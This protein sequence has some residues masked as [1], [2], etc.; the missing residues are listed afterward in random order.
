MPHPPVG[1]PLAE[2]HLRDERR[3]H[4][5]RPPEAGGRRRE[6]GGFLLERLEPLVEVAQRLVGE[7]RADL[8][9]VHEPPVV[10]HPRQQ[11]PETDARALGIGEAADHDFLL[12]HALDLE[13]VRRSGAAIDRVAPLGDGAFEAH[14]AG[15]RDELGTGADDV[16]A[17]L[18]RLGIRAGRL[19]QLREQRLPVL[20]PGI[21]EV[22]AIQVEQ[23]EDDVGEPT[24]DLSS[25]ELLKR[26]KAGGTVGQEDGHLSVHHRVLDRQ[27]RHALCDGR[28]VGR[29]VAP[30]SAQ[31]AHLR[32]LQ[33]RQDPVAVELEL[34][35]PLV[36]LGRLL[37]Q[38]RELRRD[39]LRQAAGPGARQVLPGGHPRRPARSRT[40]RGPGAA[41]GRG[42]ASP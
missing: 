38:G 2:A 41:T 9:R 14:L 28:E 42:H 25:G 18:E 13:P 34:V 39:E 31:E 24:A 5:V 20:Q 17:V 8:A 33:A 30:V 19:Q 22:V 16:I 35:E 37:D 26:L 15:A 29:P 23:V 6:R 27:A 32:V 40:R 12:P 7:A 4:P 11:R 10:V 36:P 3:L 1:G 21:G